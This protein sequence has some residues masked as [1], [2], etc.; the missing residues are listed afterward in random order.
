MALKKWSAR[1]SSGHF[2]ETSRANLEVTRVTSTIG[3]ESLDFEMES[4][5][6]SKYPGAACSAD[7]TV[8]II[9][10]HNRRGDESNDLLYGIMD[11]DT[12][13]STYFLNA[14]PQRPRIYLF[15]SGVL[16]LE[17]H[18]TLGFHCFSLAFNYSKTFSLAFNYSKTIQTPSAFVDSSRSRLP[19]IN[20]LLFFELYNSN[21]TLL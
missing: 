7:T 5:S 6:S 8:I 20:E 11:N 16:V 10:Q 3:N 17:Y 2:W 15:A 9:T 18:R 19:I 1:R 4:T 14:P 21:C 12:P 13:S